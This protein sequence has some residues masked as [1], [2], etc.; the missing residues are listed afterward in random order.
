MMSRMQN[1]PLLIKHSIRKKITILF[2]VVLLA[3]L[4]ACWLANSFFLERYYLS[5]KKEVLQGAYGRLDDASDAESL[6]SESFIRLLSVICETNNIS[7]LV[8]DNSGYVKIYTTKDYTMMRR[9][10]YDYLFGQISLENMEKMKILEEQDY[11][12][13]R[14]CQDSDSKIEYVEMIGSLKS[15]ELFLMRTALEPIRE[16][17]QL[18][19]RFLL[20]VGVSVLVIGALIIQILARRIAEPI[21]ELARLSERMSNLEFDVKFSG[22]KDDEVSFLGNQMNRM[23]EALEKTI[24]ELKTANNELQRDIEQKTRNDEMR[25]EFLSNISHE[26][27]TPIALIQGY[28][29]GLQEC[30]NDDPESRSFYCDVIMDEAVKMNRMVKN[31]LTLNEL[32]FGNEVV[33]MERF[34]LALMIRNMLQSTKILF[35][36]KQVRLVYEQETPVYVWANEYKLEE[37]LNNYISNA[38]NHVEG[39][40]VIKITIQCLP[41]RVRAGVFN[42]GKP[43]P[44]EDLGKIWD[45]FYKVDKARTREYGGSGVGLSIVKAIMES[46][47]REYGAVNYENGVEFWF[48]LDSGTKA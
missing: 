8:M 39:E 31:L 13:I 1:R 40:R 16:S 6:E 48:D 19:N 26:L 25:R 11:Y 22:K 29:E 28:A 43:I 45:K 34:D 2:S 15:G 9:R 10:L 4:S 23:S 35:E 14:M 21:L 27:K 42:T 18:A 17:V 33:T 38:L 46:M 37:V 36:Q 41:D 12:S 47:H 5:N 24:S 30:I 20:Y 7:L 44:E 32:E 3:A